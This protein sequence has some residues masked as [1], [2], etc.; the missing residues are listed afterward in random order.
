MR[1]ILLP[2]PIAMGTQ[3]MGNATTAA[4]LVAL[5]GLA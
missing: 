3:R 4:G 5:T 2:R 1:H